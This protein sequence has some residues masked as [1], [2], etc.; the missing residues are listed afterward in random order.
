MSRT[1]FTSALSALLALASHPLAAHTLVAS[2]VHS[3]A[4]GSAMTVSASPL[5]YLAG[6]I[7]VTLVLHAL[8]AASGHPLFP[9]SRKGL[10][11]VGGA[12]L[13]GVGVW[14]LATL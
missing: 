2:P 14:L 6:F 9:R 7:V 11:R 12:G 5:L 4:D 3:H 1:I 10:W 8:S 13:A